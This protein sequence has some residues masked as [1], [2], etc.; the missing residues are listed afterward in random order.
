[1]EKYPVAGLDITIEIVSGPN[2]GEAVTAASDTSGAAALTY[3]GD[4]GPGIDIIV[5]SAAHP[6]TGAVMADTSTVTWINSPP[7]CDAGGPYDVVVE[8]DTASVTPDAGASS[9]AEGDSLRFHW[10]VDCEGAWFDDEYSA[11][12]VL[13][14]T[15][16]CLCVDS[17]AVG[18]MVSDGY[19]STSCGA[20]VHIDDQRPPIIVVREEPLSIWPPNHKH[21]KIT[22]DMML[23]SAEDA[24]GN[25]IDIEDAVVMEV[26]SDEPCNDKGDGNTVGD[27]RIKCPNV[28][29]LRSERAGGGNGRVYTIVY[30]ITAENGVSTEGEARVIVPHDASSKMAIED[31]YGGYVVIPECGDEER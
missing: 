1:M 10:T 23:V 14:I 17:I 3:N 15:G 29:F 31:E 22:P 12:P 19:D 26:R 20:A 8:S 21:R 6:G 16:D 5:A 24:C 13:M 25:P 28:V 30:R 2:T 18:V 9:D 11:T 4:G 27:I 7:V